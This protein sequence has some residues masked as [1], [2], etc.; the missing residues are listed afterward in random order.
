MTFQANP[1]S[2][3]QSSRPQPFWLGSRPAVTRQW[4][5][6]NFW[7][8]AISRRPSWWGLTFMKIRESG[9]YLRIR[10]RPVEVRSHSRHLHIAVP[11]LFDHGL[12]RFDPALQQ[13]NRRFQHRMDRRERRCVGFGISSS[14]MFSKTSRVC[15]NNYLLISQLLVLHQQY[16]G[17]SLVTPPRSLKAEDGRTLMRELKASGCMEV[18]RAMKI[19]AQHLGVF[20]A[21]VYTYAK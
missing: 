11:F 20:R 2:A 9:N 8:M 10:K 21:A 5:C 3:N 18:R 16:D 13:V 19:M 7:A 15:R 6:L 4:R 12:L 14:D 1:A 17:T